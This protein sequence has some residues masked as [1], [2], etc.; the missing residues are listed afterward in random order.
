MARPEA[1]NNGGVSSTN[2]VLPSF[3]Q[4]SA[5][6]RARMSSRPRRRCRGVGTMEADETAFIS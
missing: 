4:Q 3:Q 5:N 2:P 1:A 6:P